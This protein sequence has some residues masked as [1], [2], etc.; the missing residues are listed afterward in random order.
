MPSIRLYYSILLRF[1]DLSLKMQLYKTYVSNGTDQGCPMSITCISSLQVKGILFKNIFKT[2]I[3]Q[4]HL[5]NTYSFP[6]PKQKEYVVS[7]QYCNDGSF[8]QRW[9]LEFLRPGAEISG[10]MN[11]WFLLVF[12]QHLFSLFS[13]QAIS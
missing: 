12:A 8:P 1:K 2:K 4:L 6:G 11:G 10:T 9:M 13:F 5:W 7:L 3:F